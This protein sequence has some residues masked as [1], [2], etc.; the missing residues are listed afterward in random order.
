MAAGA[1]RWRRNVAGKAPL[2]PDVPI[3]SLGN[4]QRKN[5]RH[6]YLFSTVYNKIAVDQILLNCFTPRNHHERFF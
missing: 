2:Q 3:A 5:L 4:S 1:K 6:E